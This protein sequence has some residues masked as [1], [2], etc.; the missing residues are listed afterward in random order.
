MN[1]KHTR[2]LKP[3]LQSLED[4]CV[5]TAGFLDPT[6]NGNGL[7]TTPIAPPNSVTANAVAIYPSGTAN[8]GKIVAVGQGADSKGNPDFGLVRYLPNGSLDSTFG[9]GGI[10]NQPL[11]GNDWATG[12]A[13]VGDKILA[14]GWGVKGGRSAFELARF[15]ADGSL[16]QSFGTGGWVQTSVGHYDAHSN[17]M[18]VQADGKIVLAGTADV[19]VNHNDILEFAVAR[20]NPNGT[21]D[22]TFGNNGEMIIDVGESLDRYP[23]GSS[24]VL[25]GDKIDLASIGYSSGNDY[26]VQLTFAGQL[27]KSFGTGGI[28]TLGQG[29]FPS[30]TAQGDG[31]LVVAS[32]FRG[33]HVTR[34]LT[35]GLPDTGFATGG[36]AT[37][38]WLSAQNLSTAV[39]VD[40]LGRFV[41]GCLT[42]ST[43]SWFD[44]IRLTPTGALD[45]IFGSG[46]VGTSENLASVSGNPGT[47]NLE[48]TVAMALQPDGKTVLV[49][50]NQYGTF[51]TARFTGD[52][53]LMAA[54][55]PK[56]AS[57]GTLTV[58]ET[59]P[60]LTEAEALWR[61]AGVDT[62]TLG[63]I[64]IHIADLGGAELGLAD[65]VH[66]AIWLD[67]NAAGWG[68]FVDKTRWN[69]ANYYMPGGHVP[70]DHMDLLTV[71]EH[72]VGHLLGKE[73]QAHGVMA[74]TLSPGTRRTPVANS[75][76]DWPG[77][78]DG[79]FAEASAWK[80]PT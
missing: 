48:G 66:H 55:L 37:V 44:V 14:S 57:S 75:A 40:P 10:V 31:K 36:T 9:N 7:V 2:T 1:R 71:L 11:T 56:H 16:D 74:E 26:V 24:L 59:Q 6:F 43:P 54:S 77:A 30:L 38:S 42:N 76:I 18:A 3:T 79:F 8:A 28:V 27:D 35:N 68:W 29:G 52:S 78:V 19:P 45:S 69:N 21:L 32:N 50:T 41:I 4:R 13:L 73:H 39:Q 61:A 58:K 25:S 51:A 5:L 33:N 64:E 15:N 34:L 62:S 22:T 60:L 80:K 53:A 46:G 12:V 65:E 17:A 20:Y 70:R 47:L 49:G 23:G 67:D 63:V 72:E